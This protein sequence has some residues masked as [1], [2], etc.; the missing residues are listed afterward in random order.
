MSLH[1]IRTPALVTSAVAACVAIMTI[2]GITVT[3]L[4]RASFAP[5]D[6][7]PAVQTAFLLQHPNTR[8]LK[9]YAT[10]IPKLRTAKPTADALALVTTGNSVSPLALKTFTSDQE[11]LEKPDKTLSGFPPYRQLKK[12]HAPGSMWAYM[13]ADVVPEPRTLIE[14]ISALLLLQDVNYLST[15]MENQLATLY[16]LTSPTDPGSPLQHPTR[17]WLEQPMFVMHAHDLHSHWEDALKQMSPVRQTQFAA[18]LQQFT[19]NTFGPD[20][21]A[22]YDVL[23]LLQGEATLELATADGSEVYVVITGNTTSQTADLFT[24]F[25]ASVQSKEPQIEKRTQQLLDRFTATDLRMKQSELG[26]PTLKGSWNVQSSHGLV[27]AFNEE[28]FVMSNNPAMLDRLETVQP[29]QVPELQSP[30]VQPKTAAGLLDVQAIE[31]QLTEWTGTDLQP[32]RMRG[33]YTW[34]LYDQG[35]HRTFLGKSMELH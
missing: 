1:S 11:D 35:N 9:N 13:T 26:G 33:T 28:Q 14:R 34:S 3:E 25:H 29:L 7:L 17:T 27:T 31:K 21:S 32:S 10:W 2:I 4:T 8:A 23:P 12:H 5:S 20:V 24:R 15:A 19:R 30:T 6:A 22:K 16:M 18:L